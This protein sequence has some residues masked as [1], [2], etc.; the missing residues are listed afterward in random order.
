M[1]IVCGWR[2]LVRQDLEHERGSGQTFAAFC[3]LESLPRMQ[4]INNT[5][6]AGEKILDLLPKGLQVDVLTE[7]CA[8]CAMGHR[9]AWAR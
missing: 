5:S 7:A 9:C 3:E 2:V 8:R 1:H 6:N 4:A